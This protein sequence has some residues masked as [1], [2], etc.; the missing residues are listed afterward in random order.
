MTRFGVRGPTVS[1][2]SVRL[3]HCR[4]NETHP[5][6]FGRDALAAR[7]PANAAMCAATVDALAGGNRFIAGLGLPGEFPHY[8]PWLEEGFRRR[9]GVRS[10]ENFEIY[11]QLPVVI[12]R[13]V[14]T[15]LALMKPEVDESTGLSPTRPSAFRSCISQVERKRRSRPCPM[16]WSIYVRW[17]R[18]R[19]GFALDTAHGSSQAQLASSCRPIKRSRWT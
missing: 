1:M 13:D 4:A 19:K 15:A 12:E 9:G 11:S 2:R 5:A 7:T 16:S 8:R 17:W 10:L 18:H 3:P 14:R 6:R